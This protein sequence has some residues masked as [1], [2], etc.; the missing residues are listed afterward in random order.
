MFRHYIAGAYRGA[1]NLTVIVFGALVAL[2]IFLVYSIGPFYYYYFELVNQ[3]EAAVRM[4]GE[5]TDQELRAKL[6]YHIKR[7]ELPVDSAELIIERD[8]NS[9][10]I[11]LP[12]EE[13]F[14][15]TWGDRDYEIH[16]FEFYAEAKGNL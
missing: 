12:Y 7:M 10:H 2:A 4:A 16:T 11:S 13:V 8:D 1:A 3:M 14:Y 15:V 9:I 5:Y 6:M